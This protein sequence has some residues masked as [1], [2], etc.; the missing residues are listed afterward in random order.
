M[1]RENLVHAEL[2]EVWEA[3]EEMSDPQRPLRPL[4]TLRETY[5]T[6]EYPA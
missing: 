4:L 2:G 6:L 1:M 5:F 3:A